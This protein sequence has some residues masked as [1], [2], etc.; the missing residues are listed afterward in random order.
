MVK[1]FP[2]F[3]NAEPEKRDKLF[4]SEPKLGQEKTLSASFCIFHHA[5]K[6]NNG[7]VAVIDGGALGVALGSH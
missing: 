5:R 7:N 3:S 6:A 1:A 4:I 2:K